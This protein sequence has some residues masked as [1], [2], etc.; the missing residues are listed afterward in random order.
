[1]DRA[2]SRHHWTPRNRGLP[3]LAHLALDRLALDHL[4][5]DHLALAHLALDRPD[6][7]RPDLD[8]PLDRPDLDHLA[9]DRLD[10]DDLDLDH[11]AARHVWDPVSVRRGLKN[12]RVAR[13]QIALPQADRWAVGARPVVESHPDRVDPVERPVPPDQ[14]LKS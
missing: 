6:L 10:L 7:D 9:L 2:R 1:M 13:D 5:L 11:V 4:A 12:H 14:A 8:R 3:D